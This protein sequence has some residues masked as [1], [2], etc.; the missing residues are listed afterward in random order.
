[1]TPMTLSSYRLHRHLA[2]NFEETDAYT[3]EVANELKKRLSMKIHIPTDH[4]LISRP[5]RSDGTIYF[6]RW[7]LVIGILDCNFNV[8]CRFTI[9]RTWVGLILGIPRATIHT[10]PRRLQ[11]VS[12]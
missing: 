10:T 8:Y 11:P 12:P 1:M 5:H 9:W 3:N 2:H 6:S 4:I 7:S